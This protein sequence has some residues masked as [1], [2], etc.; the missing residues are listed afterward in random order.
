MKTFISFNEAL[1]L[2]LAHVAPGETEI[3]PLE[4]LVGS[5][6]AEDVTAKVDCPSVSASRKDGFAVVSTDLDAAS[7]QNLISLEVKGS[8][9]AG[10]RRE[11]KIKSGQAV[12][13]TT[14]TRRVASSR[15][16]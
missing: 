1:E 5:V 15:S 3:L 13:V 7:K 14:G 16:R 8:L 12:R 11:L 9:S 2:T 6:L 4:R 10:D